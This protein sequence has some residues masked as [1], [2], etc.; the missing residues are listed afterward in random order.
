MPDA[1][2]TESWDDPLMAAIRPAIRE[3]IAAGNPDAWN[4]LGWLLATQPGREEETE[5]SYRRA[6][7]A[8]NTLAVN[9]LGLLLA[10]QPGRERTGIPGPADA[11]VGI[12]LEAREIG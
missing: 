5:A 3:A 8:G 9:N 10:G 11:V 2:T 6:I 12:A 7:A 4:S 1:I